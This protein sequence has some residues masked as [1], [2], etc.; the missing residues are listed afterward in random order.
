MPPRYSRP[1][2]GARIT[3]GNKFRNSTFL[4]NG[5]RGKLTS[6]LSWRAEAFSSYIAWANAGW[7][8]DINL[9]TRRR[10]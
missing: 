8:L 3:G 7:I 10:V 2:I 5:F 9:Q 4:R 6:V 1:G